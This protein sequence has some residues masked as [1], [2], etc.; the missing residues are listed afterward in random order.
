[1]NTSR[2][3]VT[4][5]LPA[6]DAASLAAAV[7]AIAAA[8]APT[9]H[10][11]ASDSDPGQQLRPE[12]LALAVSDPAAALDWLRAAGGAVESSNDPAVAGSALVAGIR[13]LVLAP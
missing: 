7:A 11:V 10:P 2:A 1:M 4:V 9:W 8:P 12:Q 5:A 3:S 13:L 6:P